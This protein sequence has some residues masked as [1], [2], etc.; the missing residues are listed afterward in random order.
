MKN[1]PLS[2]S[3]GISA[4]NEEQT[5][6]SVLDQILNQQTSNW[7]LKEIIVANDGSSD[8]TVESI[9]KIQSKKIK[10]LNDGKRLGK[11]AR[12]QQIFEIFEGEVLCLFDADIKLADKKVIDH[13]LTTLHNENVELVGGNSRPTYPKTFFERSVFTTFQVFDESRMTHLNGNNIFC[14]TG[15]CLALSK[16]LAKQIKF[17]K[18]LINED[19]YMYFTCLNNG[20]TFMYSKKAI[21]YYYL[22]QKP[23]D[24]MKQVLRSEPH[25][26]DFELRDHF[27]KLVDKELH[28]NMF[29]YLKSIFKVFIRQPIE[30]IFI[31]AINIICIPLIAIVLNNYKLEWFT[32]HS[33]HNRS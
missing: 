33:S 13:L 27:P 5:I 21:V 9:K 6:S 31:S 19:A 3:I 17:P 12:L 30:V 16:K 23:L 10:I 4:Y 2:V 32:A 29:S 20:Y 26:L 7:I 24:Y 18:K 22:P 8:K 14:C 28:R 11:T 15:S 1:K 25:A